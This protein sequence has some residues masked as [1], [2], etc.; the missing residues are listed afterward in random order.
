[1]ESQEA[2]N[3]NF[4][5]NSLHIE[6]SLLKKYCKILFI[7]KNSYSSLATQIDYD[8]MYVHLLTLSFN[9]N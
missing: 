1:M 4:N 3:N 2:N 9:L 7:E 8:I 5:L 6:L